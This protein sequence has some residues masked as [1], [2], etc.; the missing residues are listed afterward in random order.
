MRWDLAGL[1]AAAVFLGSGT[2]Q[3]GAGGTSKPHLDL[4][5]TPRI[6]FSPVEVFVVG[7]LK[8]GQDTE[9]FYC[10]GQVW[11]WGDGS[12][13]AQESDCSPYEDGAKL[14]RFFS[15]R[16]AFQA[17]GTYDVHLYLIR[18]GRMITVA[19]VPVMVYGHT[20]GGAGLGGPDD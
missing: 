9:E 4:R 8:G 11:D 1:A 16:H 17:P 20:A 15:A 12:R 13:S 2:L 7:E 14:D 5:A 19:R 18:D 10:P 6:A 3:A